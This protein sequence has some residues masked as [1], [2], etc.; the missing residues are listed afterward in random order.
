MFFP[1]VVDA[2]ARWLICFRVFKPSRLFGWRLADAM[3]FFSFLFIGR[4]TKE[5]NELDDFEETVNESYHARRWSRWQRGEHHTVWP[6]LRSVC[7]EHSPV[8]MMLRLRFQRRTDFLFL[9]S[10]KIT[11]G[12][13][14][15]SAVGFDFTKIKSGHGLV[16]ALESWR[17]YF[18][19]ANQG[20]I[21]IIDETTSRKSVL[22]KMGP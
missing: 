16:S 11:I 12:P 4:L 2:W 18:A 9:T 7:P 8:S 1:Q 21:S 22:R 10:S 5:V 17:L 6:V 3:I 14:L 19:L 13:W 20:R 15:V